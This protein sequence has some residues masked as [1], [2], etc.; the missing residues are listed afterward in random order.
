[1][2]LRQVLADGPA[3]KAVWSHMVAADVAK[4]VAVHFFDE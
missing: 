4:L 3:V 2:E 1:V